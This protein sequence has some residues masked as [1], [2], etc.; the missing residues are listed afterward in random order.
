MYKKDYIL[1]MLEMM[2]EFIAA[3]MGYIKQGEFQKA[4]QSLEKLYVDFLK[5]DASFFR[6]IPKAS[7]TE[8]L[9][10]EHNYTNEHLQ[11]LAELFYAEAEIQ[12]AKGTKNFSIDF[13]EKALHLFKF[14]EGSSKTYSMEQQDK[15]KAIETKLSAM[16]VL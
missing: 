12:Y 16:N 7:L 3:I 10:A 6:S 2:G 5:Q 9:M 8:K 15:I 14:L 1:K 13:Y 11:I 4:D